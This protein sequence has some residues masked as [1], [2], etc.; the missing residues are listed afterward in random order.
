MRRVVV[1]A[2]ESLCAAGT[3]RKALM[4]ALKQNE[5]LGVPS[6]YTL[7]VDLVGR[8]TEE[9]PELYNSNHSPFGHAA[10]SY[11]FGFGMTSLIQTEP[12]HG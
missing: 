4:R 8:Y 12:P 10:S 11:P 2:A 3:G 5:C 6:G 7:P 9:V 1:T